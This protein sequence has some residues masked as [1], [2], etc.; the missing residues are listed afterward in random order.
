MFTVTQER[1]ERLREKER[2]LEMHAH[3]L[4]EE[5]LARLGE[6]RVARDARV[7]HE[8]VEFVPTEHARELAA[9]GIGEAREARAVAHVLDEV[10]DAAA[11]HRAGRRVPDRRRR[12]RGRRGLP[13]H[14]L[15]R[16]VGDH[17]FRAA[18]GEVQGHAPAE[19]AAAAGDER[20]GGVSR[21]VVHAAL[22]RSTTPSGKYPFRAFTS[23]RFAPAG[24]DTS[25]QVISSRAL[26]W[27]KCEA[28]GAPAPGLIVAAD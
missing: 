11:R 4:V 22:I 25:R 20:D 2:P 23:E 19:S 18:V 7:V 8:V 27:V 10:R 15:F 3:E 24:G 14:G 21:S 13:R 16:A 26:P 5:R 12:R 9:Q 1:Q 6:G 17:H 28:D